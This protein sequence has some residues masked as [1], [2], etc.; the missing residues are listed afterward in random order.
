MRRTQR[1]VT[2]FIVTLGLFTMFMN[3]PS[4][5]VT[6]GGPLLVTKSGRPFGWRVSRPV[7]WTPDQGRLGTL[8]NS[9]AIALV[10]ETFQVWQDVPTAR[11][12]FQQSGQLDRD[13]TQSNFLSFLDGLTNDCLEGR[14]CVN[15]IIFDTDG[16][17]ID[18][19]R[20]RGA[21]QR[22]LG[23]AGPNVF[24]L[25]GFI[26]QGV[27]V[28]NGRFSRQLNLLRETCIHEFG[29][30]IGLDHTALNSEAALD[31]DPSNDAIVPIMAPIVSGT[32]GAHLRLDDIAA[33]SSLYPTGDFF[34]AGR[35]SGQV[36]LPDG[37]GFQG[38][39][40]VARKVDDPE[41]TAVS[42]VSG[43]L[44]AGTREDPENFG[45]DSPE[46]LGFYEIR[47]LPDGRY[48]VEIESINPLFNG[49]S[50][51]GPLDPPE[52]LPGPPEFYSGAEESASDDPTSQVEIELISP[53][54]RVQEINII[55]N[56]T[57]TTLRLKKRQPVANPR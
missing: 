23:F 53:N 52:A 6:A 31:S 26:L 13:V 37:T 44:H 19:L 49:G 30:M 27:A 4:L 54:N 28:L 7:P 21:S 3:L 18:S 46:L 32:I 34:G 41:L 2:R 36:L 12:Q 38:A 5:D 50:A 29:H 40:V 15:P 51:V 16:R 47:G 57:S 33:V 14:P 9:D 43:F 55:L 17:I 24:R 10:A 56:T 20:G 11:I 45:S 1:F 48:T 39:N 42:S 25:D 35:I 8:S 22:I